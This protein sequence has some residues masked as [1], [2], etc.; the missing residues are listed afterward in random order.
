MCS[1]DCNDPDAQKTCLISSNSLSGVQV[2]MLLELSNVLADVYRGK[3][4]SCTNHHGLGGRGIILPE[5]FF[6]CTVR[7]HP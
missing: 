7:V 5:I 3:S 6:T 2:A 4:T 1:N